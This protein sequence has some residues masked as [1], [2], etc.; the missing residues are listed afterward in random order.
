MTPHTRAEIFASRL[1]SMPDPKD[2]KATLWQSRVR[3]ARV[4]WRDSAE[5][6]VKDIL[7][8]PEVPEDCTARELSM[9]VSMKLAMRKGEMSL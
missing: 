3:D 7:S 1:R 2:G 5:T 6:V 8:D 4:T 9:W